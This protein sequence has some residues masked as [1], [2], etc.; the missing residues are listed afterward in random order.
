MPGEFDQEYIDARR[1]LLDALDALVPHHSALTLVGAQAIY[2]HVGA[3]DLAIAEY[4]SDADLALNPELLASEPVLEETLRAGGF[5][6]TRQPGIWTKGAES[7]RTVDLLVPAASAG[8]GRRAARIPPHGRNVARSARGLEGV[9]ADREMM[10]IAALDTDDRR[11][12]RLHVAGPAALVVAK[13]I[14]IKERSA[15][16]GR[17]VA[18]DALD[19]LRI[20]RGVETDRLS[21]GLR[22]LSRHEK[23]GNVTGE[24]IDYLNAEFRQLG[25]FGSQLAVKATEHIEDP[26]LIAQSCAIL[27]DALVRAMG[28]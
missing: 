28:L 8:E 1:I 24:A 22:R 10:A 7:T 9:L 16:T 17:L 25:G 13:V 14:K 2:L 6:P 23:A 12:H 5:L 27:T 20:L 21:E 18:K 11:V 19:V 15:D 3:A 4:T 26:A